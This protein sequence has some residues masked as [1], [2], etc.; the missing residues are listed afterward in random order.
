M[1]GTGRRAG[2]FIPADEREG[3]PVELPGVGKLVSKPEGRKG[4]G[5]NGNKG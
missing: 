4:A 5:R 3:K 2:G 1:R